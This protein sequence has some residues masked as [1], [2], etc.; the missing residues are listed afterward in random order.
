MLEKKG[1]CG[2]KKKFY[3]L[4][5]VLHM[6]QIMTGYSLQRRL[7]NKAITVSSVHPGYVSLHRSLLVVRGGLSFKRLLLANG[8]RKFKVIHIYTFLGGGGGGGGGKLK[9]QP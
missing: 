6:Y 1:G 2:K 3:I 4:M 9:G 8:C 5:C 7:Q